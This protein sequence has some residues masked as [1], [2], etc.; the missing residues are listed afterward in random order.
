[1]GGPSGIVSGYDLPAFEF[2]LC[3]DFFDLSVL[4]TFEMLIKVD[5][6][7]SRTASLESVHLRQCAEHEELQDRIAAELQSVSR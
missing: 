7:L 4:A 3:H 2:E 5:E 6:V 1:M